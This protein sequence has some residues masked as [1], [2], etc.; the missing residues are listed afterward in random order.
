MKLTKKLP[1]DNIDFYYILIPMSSFAEKV[2]GGTIPM[3]GIY[4]VTHFEYEVDFDTYKVGL[5]LLGKT[6]HG[7]I[8]HMGKETLYF[9]GSDYLY[10]DGPSPEVRKNIRVVH[11]GEQ[12][13]FVSPEWAE[14]FS[15]QNFY[16]S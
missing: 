5:I 7:T 14:D 16:S 8:I 2:I 1:I 12:V 15:L 6:T 4:K 10:L 3:V 9:I 13:S 11:I